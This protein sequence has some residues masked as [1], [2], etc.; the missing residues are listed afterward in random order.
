M[1]RKFDRKLILENGEVYEGYGFGEYCDRVCEIIFNTS[2]VGYQEIIYNPAYTYQGVVM[3]YPLIGNYGITDDVFED[4]VASVSALF[5]REYNDSPSNFRSTKT[6]SEV[7]EEN[8]IPGIY[9]F[10]TRKLTRSLRSNGT[11]RGLVTGIDTSVEEG[12]EI[13][14]NTPEPRDAVA[15]VSC[16]RRWYLRTSNRTHNVVAI[17]CGL[18]HSVIRYLNNKECNVTVVPWNTSAEEI[19]NM[20]PDGIFFSDGPGCPEDVPELIELV[21]SFK[22]KYP[23]FGIGLGHQII[24]LAYGA[25]MTR[26][27][28]GHHGSNY[29][30]KNLDTGKIFITSQCN[31][32]T[33]DMGSLENTDLRLIH[34]SIL[35]NTV[36]AVECAKDGVICVEYDP[37]SA[38]DFNVVD[39]FIANMKEAE[40]NA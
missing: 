13:I 5:V 12:L 20:K 38:P 29:P 35:D 23:I 7:L 1:A 15:S 33:V 9:G 22:G 32:Y 19:I 6:L 27:K 4:K 30:V 14:K 16:K 39:K 24:C 28:F 31:N 36:A 8:H 3:T 17:D 26:L 21:R 11:M 37:E 25:K 10:D 2:M 40:S 18:K 34:V